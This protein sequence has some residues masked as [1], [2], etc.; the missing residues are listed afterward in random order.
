MES[1]PRCPS[2][3]GGTL[4]T[5]GP[6]RA[7]TV[8]AEEQL[9]GWTGGE[10]EEGGVQRVSV[11]DER[12][13]EGVTAGREHERESQAAAG[14]EEVGP[15]FDSGCWRSG[16]GETD[17]SGRPRERGRDVEPG[18]GEETGPAGHGGEDG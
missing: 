3:P 13:E 18:R 15:L 7:G 5:L 6:G 4:G 1:V 10:G 2:P 9:L 17:R 16:R 11:H 12:G 14:W 8:A